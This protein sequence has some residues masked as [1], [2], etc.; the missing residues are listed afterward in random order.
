MKKSLAVL[1]VLVVAIVLLW[2]NYF[3]SGTWRYQ[4]TVEIETPE[5][6]KSGSAVREVRAKKNIAQWLNPDV[7]HMSYEVIGE[8]VII[9]LD[10]RGM[11]FALINWNSYG[12]VH[13]AFPYKTLDSAQRVKYYRNLKPGQKAE[14][15]TSHPQI[16]MFKDLNDPN[17]VQ[18]VL[19]RRFNVKTQKHDPVDDFETIFGKSVRLKQITIEIT[20]D[21]VTWGIEKWLPWLGIVGGGYLDGRFSGGGP[22]LSNILHGGNFKRGK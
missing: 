10:E 16:V 5:G 14:L 6:I 19:G 13:N 20:N 2:K 3:P 15:K 9:D 18:L 8:A 17:S 21:R 7:R 11:M 4:I 12:E 1:G 22:E